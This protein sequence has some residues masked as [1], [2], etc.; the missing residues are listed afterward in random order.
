[1]A[2]RWPHAACVLLGV[3]LCLPALGPHRV[4]DDA[5]LELS[6]RREAFPGLADGLLGMFRFASGD[7][8]Q[9]R[10]L[11]ERGVLLPWWSDPTLRI[12]FLRPLSGL[13]HALDFAYWPG[14]SRLMYAHSLVWLGLMIAAAVSLYRR[15]EPDARL[16]LGAAL[17]FAIDPAHG[18]AVGWL[19]SRNTLM[20]TLFGLCAIAAWARG[21]RGL[22]LICV[23]VSLLC[24]EVGICALAYLGCHTWILDPRPARARLVSLVP[25]LVVTVA[26]RSLHAASGFGARGSG[27]YL[28]PLYD[29]A[30]FL[31]AL[32]GRYAGSLGAA[33][34][35]VPADSLFAGDPGHASVGRVAGIIALLVFG[36]AIRPFLR[37]DPVARFW[38]SGSLLAALPLCAAPPNDRGLFFVG[39][40]LNALLARL[41]LR[42]FESRPAKLASG[43]LVGALAIACVGW[44]ALAR[45]II[46]ALRSRE[47][48]ALGR[49]TD[50]ADRVLDSVPELER[51]TVVV[52]NPPRDIFA[53]Y[54]Q[55][56][57][58][59][60]GASVARHWYWLSSVSSTLTVQRVAADALEVTREGG[61]FSTP[62]ERLYRRDPTALEPG[63]SIDVD[64]FRAVVVAST[65]DGLP[66]TVRFHFRVPLEHASFVFLAWHEGRYVRVAPPGLGQTLTFEWQPLERLL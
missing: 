50:G 5:V 47:V 45:P 3:G 32:P 59:V 31:A 2:V 27:A 16:A 15:I 35:L 53:S 25:L 46:L 11:I 42:F 66:A 7:P 17:L 49:R 19:S 1:V 34:S 58:K 57:R 12:A 21:A 14:S 56:E 61:F 38:A 40:G 24:G 6:L 55:L 20:A 62:L 54:V 18:P 60:R 30:A 37:D 10:E 36:F 43:R 28:D 63:T 33:L 44:H 52:L 64:R 65:G 48:Q 23:A 39:L 29:G 9:N 51:R 4:L 22:S 13:T 41:A 26:W 8:P